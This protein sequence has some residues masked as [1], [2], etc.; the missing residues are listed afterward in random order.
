MTDIIYGRNACLE[1]L[2]LDKVE[3]LY[4][5]KGKLKGSIEKIIGKAKDKRVII[6]YVDKKALDNMSQG[7]VHQGVVAQISQFHYSSVEDIL[8][9]AKERNEDPF[10]VLLDEI[11]DPHNLGAIMRTCET[12]GVH[13]IIIPKRRSATVNSTVYKSSAGA[14]NYIKVAKVTNLNRTIDDLKS[15]NIFVYGTDG[16]AK[17]YYNKT[18]LTGPIALVIGNEGKGISQMIKENCDELIKIPM[19]GKISSLN[20]SNACA[21]VCYEVLRQRDE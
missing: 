18:N 12:A 11:E 15:K 7:E 9:V 4:I 10:I 3:T 14:A 19:K 20:A 6:K 13:G 1:A 8:N 5:Q 2:N 21:I 16:D 17:S